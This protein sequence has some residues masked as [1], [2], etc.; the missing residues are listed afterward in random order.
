MAKE[1]KDSGSG[2]EKGPEK[3]RSR[4]ASSADVRRTPTPQMFMIKTH[5]QKKLL[6]S[7]LLSVFFG[8]HGTWGSE[9]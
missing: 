7:G 2:A 8:L 5:H 6:D 9:A 3:G 1:R 4:V